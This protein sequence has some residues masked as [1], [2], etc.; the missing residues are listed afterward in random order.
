MKHFLYYCLHIIKK[1]FLNATKTHVFKCLHGYTLQTFF[2]EQKKKELENIL[3]IF[4]IL[5][6][7][8]NFFYNLQTFLVSIIINLLIK[9]ILKSM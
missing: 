4:R 7:K 6:Q 1:H 8:M 5:V 3:V 2:S 9:S